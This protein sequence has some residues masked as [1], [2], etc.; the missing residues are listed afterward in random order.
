MS[1]LTGSLSREWHTNSRPAVDQGTESEADAGACLLPVEINGNK[2]RI[3]LVDDE[4]TIRN[5]T[6]LLLERRG[7][8]VIT[9]KDGVIGLLAFAANPN[10]AAVITDLRMPRADGRKLISALRAKS[11]NGVLPIICMTGV[12]D[13]AQDTEAF[14]QQMGINTVLQKPFTDKELMASLERELS[15]V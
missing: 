10:F 2:R 14:K 3:L 12:L 4:P 15:S 13:G 6:K 5:V 1:K 8:E 9:A 11:P 7:F